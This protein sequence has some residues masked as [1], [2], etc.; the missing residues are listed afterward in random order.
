LLIDFLD[1]VWT[2]LRA[3]NGRFIV[4]KNSIWKT[5]GI[6]LISLRKRILLQIWDMWLIWTQD[7]KN[8]TITVTTTVVIKSVQNCY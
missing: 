8:N 7:V 1:S 2:M 3:I 6:Y 5:T 4:M